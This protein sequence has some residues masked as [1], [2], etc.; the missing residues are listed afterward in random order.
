MLRSEF[1]IK[2]NGRTSS[3]I[4]KALA[5]DMQITETSSGPTITKEERYFAEMIE[6]ICFL[7]SFPNSKY[8]DSE[9]DFEEAR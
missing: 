8:K 4:D 6:E 1:N 7:L 3:I 9:W 2:Q 5:R